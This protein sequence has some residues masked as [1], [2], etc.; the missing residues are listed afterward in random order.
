MRGL[1]YQVPPHQES[2]IVRALQGALW[3]VIL[4]LRKESQP[5]VSGIQ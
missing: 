5:S 2:K 3:D 1:H 4:D